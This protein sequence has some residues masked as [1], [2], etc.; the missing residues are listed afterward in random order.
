MRTVRLLISGQVQ[1]VGFRDWMVREAARHG[2]TGWVRN[3]GRAQVEAVVQG[4]AGAVEAMI[5]ASRAGPPASRVTE[6][7][8]TEAAPVAERGF[9][10]YPSA[11]GG[12]A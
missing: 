3:L 7:T 4:E 12:V 10:R 11:G 9:A 6:V 5:A 8:V 2:V 1:G